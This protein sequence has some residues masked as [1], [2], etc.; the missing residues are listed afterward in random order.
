M[1]IEEI[2]EGSH[3]GVY[4]RQWWLAGERSW[5][6]KG[7]DS[8]LYHNV[9][10]IWHKVKLIYEKKKKIFVANIICKSKTNRGVLVTVKECWIRDY[11]Q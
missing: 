6:S 1:L 9:R 4:W 3:S 7:D 10:F 8:D 2:D 5:R 11:T